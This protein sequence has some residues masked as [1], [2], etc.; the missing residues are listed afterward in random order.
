M[1]WLLTFL[2]STYLEVMRVRGTLFRSTV[3]LT[4]A[5]YTGASYTEGCPGAGTLM[6]RS[7][8]PE[9]LSRLARQKAARSLISNTQSLTISPNMEGQSLCSAS[10]FRL[11]S[12]AL[13]TNSWRYCSTRAARSDDSAPPSCEEKEESVIH[14]DQLLK[15][16]QVSVG[17]VEQRSAQPFSQ[18]LPVVPQLLRTQ[19]RTPATPLQQE[20]Q[21]PLPSGRERERRQ[22]E[23]AARSFGGCYVAEGPEHALCGDHVVHGHLRQTGL[24]FRVEV[25]EAVDGEGAPQS[26]ADHWVALQVDGQLVQTLHLSQ[27]RQLGQTADVGFQEDQVLQQQIGEFDPYSRQC[28]KNGV[29]ADV[30]EG[31]C[32]DGA[33][34]LNSPAPLQGLQGSGSKQAQGVSVQ[35]R[36]MK[37]TAQDGLLVPCL[38]GYRIPI[39]DLEKRK[40]EMIKETDHRYYTNCGRQADVLQQAKQD[41]TRASR[42]PLFACFSAV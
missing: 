4:L 26:Q 30:A 9:S 31:D 15:E 41:T 40:T 6:C 13:W 38:Q 5:S 21:L 8:N 35:L 36:Q 22:E 16:H 23:P 11:V 34:G 37:H 14:V 2:R 33:R 1:D 12:D 32:G 17:V 39:Q 3:P 10:P 27:G 20:L 29:E 42:C 18:E 24:E 7:M 28:W 19:R 25:V